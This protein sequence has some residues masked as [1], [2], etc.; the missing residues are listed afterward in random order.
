VSKHV[1]VHWRDLGPLGCDVP[2]FLPGMGARAAG[3]GPL[4]ELLRTIYG[5]AMA[6]DELREGIVFLNRGQGWPRFSRPISA[7]RRAI[8]SR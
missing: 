5:K 8:A 6:I 1:Y 4:A 7:D 3:P 2:V